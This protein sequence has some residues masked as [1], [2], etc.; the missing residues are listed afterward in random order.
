MSSRGHL[1]IY[2]LWPRLSKSVNE[3]DLKASL[4]C[5]QKSF[6]SNFKDNEIFGTL[7]GC[8]V[9][10]RP[11]N[12]RMTKDS[13]ERKSGVLRCS[14]LE[15]VPP[16]SEILIV[17]PKLMAENLVESARFWLRFLIGL[18]CALRPR[19]NTTF[20]KF[21][22]PSALS[23]SDSNFCSTALRYCSRT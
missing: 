8:D 9:A 12:A 18:Q 17:L 4:K 6:E 2:H 19:R 15:K 11:K 14:H 21:V 7:D 13:I 23:V 10:I 1:P 16:K 20:L 22:K 3:Y 5:V